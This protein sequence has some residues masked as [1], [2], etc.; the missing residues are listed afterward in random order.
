MLCADAARANHFAWNVI[1]AHAKKLGVARGG[2]LLTRT[3]SWLELME[4]AQC[5]WFVHRFTIPVHGPETAQRRWQRGWQRAFWRKSTVRGIDRKCLLKTQSQE[6]VNREQSGLHAFRIT[7]TGNM[8]RPIENLFFCRCKEA[9]FA[10][11]H[12]SCLWSSIGAR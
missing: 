2:M 12:G 9:L 4:D 5:A 7:E 6:T 10:P 8:C 3:F 1:C 11:I